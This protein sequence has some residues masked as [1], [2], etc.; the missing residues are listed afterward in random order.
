MLK[1][2]LF[3]LSFT[4]SSFSYA[5]DKSYIPTVMPPKEEVMRVKDDD[6][7][8]GCSDAKHVII[9]YSSLSCPY[10][11]TYHKTVFPQIESDII[12][13]CKAKYVYRSFPTTRS[14]LKGS[15]VA[16]CLATDNGKIDVN[17]F[18][19]H[20]HFLFASQSS[21]A[22]QETYEE[23]LNKLFLL[24]GVDKVKLNQCIA[25][26]ELM[27]DI[28]SKSFVSMK[29]LNLVHSPVIFVDGAEVSTLTFDQINN[30]VK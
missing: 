29:V 27:S 2:C 8:M 15:A 23:S 19:Y 6:V 5:V 25:D 4:L 3:I 22:F 11:A 21:W 9:E 14:A 7:V 16:Q 13:K 12:K 24:S 28:V 10:C 17:K 26:K 1:S 20:I 30:A 18:F